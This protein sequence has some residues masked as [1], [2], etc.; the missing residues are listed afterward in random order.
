MGEETKGD[1]KR[2]DVSVAMK[3]RLTVTYRYRGAMLQFESTA[4]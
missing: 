1:G 3:V 4:T 2:K